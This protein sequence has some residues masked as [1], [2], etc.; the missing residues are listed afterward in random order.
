MAT[1]TMATPTPATPYTYHGP[2]HALRLQRRHPNHLPSATTLPTCPQ[3]PPSPPALSHHPHQ[4]AHS[5]LASGGAAARCARVARGLLHHRYIT[6]T[7][8]L[9]HRYITVT[10]VQELLEGLADTARLGCLEKTVRYVVITPCFLAI[11]LGC[12]EKI[13]S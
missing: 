8:P 1:L 10:G 6:V 4:A 3:P 5:R 9:H 11:P 7:Q 13:G 12:L 2:R